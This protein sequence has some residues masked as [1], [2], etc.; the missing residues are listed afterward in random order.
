MDHA[1]RMRTMWTASLLAMFGCVVGAS[2]PQK[3]KS[4]ADAHALAAQ[5][6]PVRVLVYFETNTASHRRELDTVLGQRGYE[7]LDEV[8]SAAL[9][10]VDDHGIGELCASRRIE[11]LSAIDAYRLLPALIR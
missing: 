5:S 11:Q 1:R 6:S 2:S 3:V 8:G 9:I 4:C 7:P 10:E